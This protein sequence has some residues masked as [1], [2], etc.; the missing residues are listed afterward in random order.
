MYKLFLFTFLLFNCNL[1][2]AQQVEG[3]VGRTC[4][5]KPRTFVSTLFNHNSYN[6]TFTGIKGTST[7]A[8]PSCLVNNQL[9]CIPPGS[10]PRCL[11]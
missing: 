5:G 1:L 3:Q 9:M 6:F 8:R 7:C 10:L 4:E 11:T 2:F